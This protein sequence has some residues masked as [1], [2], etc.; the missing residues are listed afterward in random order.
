MMIDREIAS[1]TGD[2]LAAIDASEAEIER[3]EGVDF[4]DFSAAMRKKYGEG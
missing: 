1:L 4:D 3:G 2:D